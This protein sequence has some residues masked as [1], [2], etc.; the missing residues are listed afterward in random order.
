[1]EENDGEPV[2]NLQL[3]RKAHTNKR[4]GEIDDGLVREVVDMITTLKDDEELRLSQ[5]QTELDPSSTSSVSLSTA[6]INE[7]VESVR[8]FNKI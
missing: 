7:I 4:T 6:R 8:Y 2:D 1:M 5:L 3:L